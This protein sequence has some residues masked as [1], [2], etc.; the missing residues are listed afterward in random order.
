MEVEK[1]K[2][3][4]VPEVGGRHNVRDYA[5]SAAGPAVEV[6]HHKASVAPSGQYNAGHGS[7][8]NA[9]SSVRG[10]RS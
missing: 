1:I 10:R 6:Q 3:M 5:R 7:S 4:G 2:M 9:S 8:D